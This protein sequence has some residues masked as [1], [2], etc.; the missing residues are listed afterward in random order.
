MIS[1]DHGHVSALSNPGAIE[2]TLKIAE[3]CNIDLTQKEYHLPIF[4]V[5]KGETPQTTLR[6]LCENGLREKYGDR[7]ESDPA[8]RERIEKELNI[9]H[10]QKIGRCSSGIASMTLICRSSGS[11]SI[12]AE[13][14]LYFD[15]SGKGGIKGMR[16]DY[17][18]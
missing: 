3:R 16:P 4:P 11:H 8:V 9:I 15:R 13:S 14:M 2:N 5:P 18:A 1:A 10:H 17:Q 6:K 7:V 12:T